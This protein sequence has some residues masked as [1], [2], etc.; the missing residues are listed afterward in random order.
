MR[1]YLH[2]HLNDRSVDEQELHG[3]AIVRSGRYHIAKTLLES[4]AA[5]VE[6]L[7]PDNPLIFSA[8]PFAG[9]NFSN[10]N[11]TSVGCKSPLTGGIKESNSGGTFSL[12]LGQLHLAG[13]TLYGA[14]ADWSVIRITK[15]G[16]VSFD[17]A[18]SYLGKGNVE[19]AAMLK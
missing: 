5:S 11:R 6:P 2:I 12:A 9:T 3:E 7:S 14:S 19:A 17:P 15:D 13:L 1:K 4:G 16:G 8:G 18:E 10:A